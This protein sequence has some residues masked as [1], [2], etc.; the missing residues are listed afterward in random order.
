MQGIMPGPVYLKYQPLGPSRLLLVNNSSEGVD[1]EV[2]GARAH[3]SL[4]NVYGIGEVGA[5]VGVWN[6]FSMLLLF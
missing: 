2:A 6:C 4:Y 5:R 3:L 1:H